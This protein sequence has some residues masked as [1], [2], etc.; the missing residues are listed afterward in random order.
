LRRKVIPKRMP[1]ENIF[2]SFH[3]YFTL[4]LLNLAHKTDVRLPRESVDT[5]RF[6]AITL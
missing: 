2:E 5:F 1:G 4:P 6:L 3:R